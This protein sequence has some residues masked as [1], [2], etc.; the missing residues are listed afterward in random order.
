MAILVT[1]RTSSIT[2]CWLLKLLHEESFNSC[3]RLYRDPESIR[4]AT[5]FGAAVCEIVRRLP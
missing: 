1:D 4:C 3:L 5:P 2:P